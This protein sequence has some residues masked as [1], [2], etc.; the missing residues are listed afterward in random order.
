MSPGRR[1]VLADGV[2]QPQVEHRAGAGPREGRL[3]L[4]GAHEAAGACAPAGNA[5]H[6]MRA[7]SYVAS[8][9]AP[10]ESRLTHSARVHALVGPP[11]K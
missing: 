3:A 8:R 11:L 5:C 1:T 10:Y 9:S 6:L 4:V 2:L 7:L